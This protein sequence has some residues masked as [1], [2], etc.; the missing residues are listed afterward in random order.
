MRQSKALKEKYEKIR[1]F[2]SGMF[3]L[4]GFVF[5]S[6][7]PPEHTMFKTIVLLISLLFVL[8]GLFA[9]TLVDK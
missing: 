3:L 6:V 4:I 9:L 5:A 2:I 7:L 1:C 8:M